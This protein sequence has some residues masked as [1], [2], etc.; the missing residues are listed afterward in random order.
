MVM[1]N[2]R[3]VTRMGDLL[4]GMETRMETRMERETQSLKAN[5]AA[6]ADII[7][8]T[9]VVG[10]GDIH[11][12][13]RREKAEREKEENPQESL[14]PLIKVTVDPGAADLDHRLKIAT[15]TAR[16]TQVQEFF[17]FLVHTRN[18]N[19][20]PQPKQKRNQNSHTF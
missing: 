17:D 7:A 5:T 13:R 18:Q 16:R 10:G 20:K 2:Q 9:V 15:V 14:G 12:D 11:I 3:K 8:G 6:V 19:P 4:R 1:G